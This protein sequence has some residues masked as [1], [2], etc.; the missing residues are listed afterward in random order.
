VAIATGLFLAHGYCTLAMPGT[1]YR[2]PILTAVSWGVGLPYLAALAILIV[3][4]SGLRKEFAHNQGLNKLILLGPVFIAIPVAAFGVQH[5][6][7]AQFI[8]RM[9]PRWIPGHMFWALLVGVCLI[10]AALSIAARRYGWLSSALLGVMIFLFVCLISVPAIAAAP[11]NRLL[12][13]VGLRDLAFSAGAFSLAA[14]HKEAWRK[15]DRDR[16]STP[17]RFIVAVAITFFGV[18]QVLHPG[19][20]PGVPLAKLTPLWIPVHLLWGYATGAVFVV[21]GVCLLI[22][23]QARLAATW[24]GLVTLLLVVIIYVPI[25]VADPSDIGIAFNYLV[26]TLL[27]SGTL[28]A[29]AGAL[30]P[31]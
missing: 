11:R 3:G 17:A 15:R 29:L 23:K 6:T 4:L 27:L 20:T 31:G 1:A 30:S 25:V 8:A 9:V 19:F 28:L 7:A 12:W 2:L 5:F 21:G 26:D 10:A 22:K 24:L 13:A 18:E 14:S 16:V